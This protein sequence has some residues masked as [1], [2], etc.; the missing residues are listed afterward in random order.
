MVSY[1]VVVVV[2][3]VVVDV[4]ILVL[5]DRATG[6]MLLPPTL[7]DRLRIIN[8]AY[9]ILVRYYIQLD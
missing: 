1:G 5:F 8:P 4:D 2:V 3:V 7:L 6:T 9:H